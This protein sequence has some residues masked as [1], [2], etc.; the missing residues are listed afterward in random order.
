MFIGEF[1]VHRIAVTANGIIKTLICTAIILYSG[2]YWSL[3]LMLLHSFGAQKIQVSSC[4]NLFYY[5]VNE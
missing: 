1:I 2:Y 4:K 5:K 3:F